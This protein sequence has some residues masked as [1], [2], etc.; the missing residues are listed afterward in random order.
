MAI[1][2]IRITRQE[3]YEQVWSE[4][5]LKI[6]KKFGIS[7]VGLIK[8]CKKFQIPYPQRG[9]WT[10]KKYCKEPPRPSLSSYN[11]PQIIE[12]KIRPKVQV[13]RPVDIAQFK[14]AEAC[15][16]FEK[17]NKN[18]IWVSNSLR[19]LHPFVKQTRKTL[20]YRP[21]IFKDIESI[22]CT[23]SSPALNIH[24]T[25][26]SWSRALRIMSALIKALEYRGFRV[27]IEVKD[28]YYSRKLSKT[29]VSILGEIIEFRLREN[30]KR[31]K[32]ELP[33]KDWWW[34]KYEFL[35]IPTGKLSLEIK[36]WSTLRKKWSDGKKQQQLENCL[37][38]FIIGLIR[39][40]VEKRTQKNERIENKK[41]KE[42]SVK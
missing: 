6:A 39:T 23:G 29:C 1:D 20:N 7:D 13:I 16:A 9:Y 18:H 27:F 17:E 40:A 36:Y 12:F 5:I 14:Q 35:N 10:K 15:I 2:I 21:S 42:I 19:S 4:P 32:K 3:L 33:P 11:G 24:V 37:N 22:L 34:K 25:K 8:K 38:G 31:I 28:N 30:L 26:K 41:R